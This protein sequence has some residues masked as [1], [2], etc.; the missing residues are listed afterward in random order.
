MNDWLGQQNLPGG[1]EPVKPTLEIRLA[2]KAWNMMR[3]LDWVALPTVAEIIGL[4]DIELLVA[5]LCALRDHQHQ[6]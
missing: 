3:G 6:E 1:L 5:Q 4:A 2:L